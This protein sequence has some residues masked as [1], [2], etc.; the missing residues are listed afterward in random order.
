MSNKKLRS[1]SLRTRKPGPVLELPDFQHA[2]AVLTVEDVWR[3]DVIQ[4]V[5]LQRRR[6]WVK[7]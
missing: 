2:V 1:H 4:G 5:V 3:R 6:R 7:L